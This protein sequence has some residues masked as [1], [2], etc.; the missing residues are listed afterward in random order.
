MAVQVD[1][2]LRLPE[3]EYFAQPQ[4]KSGIALS[5]SENRLA[6]RVSMCICRGRQA[7]G[8]GLYKASEGGVTW[9]GPPVLRPRAP[10]RASAPAEARGR[11]SG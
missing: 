6:G 5:L 2:S 11:R 3:S 9:A 8:P 7:R 1:R 4:A 10:L